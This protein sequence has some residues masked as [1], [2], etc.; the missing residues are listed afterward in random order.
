MQSIFMVIPAKSYF[1]GQIS[2][3]EPPWH[4]QTASFFVTTQEKRQMSS[5]AFKPQAVGGWFNIGLQASYV[6]MQNTLSIMAQ[7]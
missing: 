7:L 5:H 2:S 4:Q 3:T 1:W 6:L